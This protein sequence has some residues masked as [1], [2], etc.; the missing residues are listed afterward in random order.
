M[1]ILHVT[2]HFHPCIGGVE[3]FV[4]DLCLNLVEN[5]IYC[6]VLCLDKCP[7]AGRKLPHTSDFEGIKV[8][9]TGFFDLKYYKPSF[10]FG[11]ILGLVQEYD[12]VH[13]HSLGFF[14][15][16]FLAT[17]SLHKK[18]VIV[19]THGGIWHTK[20][21]LPLKNIYVDFFQRFFLLS[22]ADAVIADSNNDFE[23]FSKK[24][25]KTILIENAVNTSRFLAP[26]EKKSTDSFI[27]LGRLSR[28]KNLSALIGSF[29]L[30]CNGRPSAKLFIVGKNFDEDLGN[31]EKIVK[32]KN[33]EKNVF[34]TGELGEEKLRHIVN[35]CSYCVYSSSFEGFGISVLELMGAGLI[36]V[37]NNIP[38][39]TR[40]VDH[41]K[42]GF[43]TDFLD[44]S[45]AARSILHALNLG[46]KEK[47]RL[48]SNAAEKAK[49][50]SWG[51]KISPYIETYEKLIAAGK[52]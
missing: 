4:K 21:F 37:L 6:E 5:G 9:R 29:A 1:K 41:E 30:V 7:K 39:F 40:F 16:F 28:N 8:T 35:E 14:S 2:N 10:S 25:Q 3:T 15:D 22:R 36:P 26:K 45:T 23:I 18:P 43:I 34:F 38:T 32:E 31:L 50:F 51:E 13:V 19:S 47:K 12:V 20:K 52:T 17:K 24:F 33:L 49:E 11:K 46:E 48:S 42:N 27:F 44:Y